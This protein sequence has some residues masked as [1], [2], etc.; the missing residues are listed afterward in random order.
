MNPKDTLSGTYSEAKLKL[1]DGSEHIVLVRMV[2]QPNGSMLPVVLD[3]AAAEFEARFKD[4]TTV[5][6]DHAPQTTGAITP[7]AASA[8]LPDDKSGCIRLVAADMVMF[9]GD[10]HRVVAQGCLDSDK[11]EHLKAHKASATMARRICMAMGG[12]WRQAAQYIPTHFP[13]RAH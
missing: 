9:I 3:T 13:D 1:P 12:I 2:K 5:P 11:L 6:A 7:K 4:T 8:L 10:P